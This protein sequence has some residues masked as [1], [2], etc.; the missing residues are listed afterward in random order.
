VLCTITEVAGHV[1]SLFGLNYPQQTEAALTRFLV[2][3]FFLL[4]NQQMITRITQD[5]KSDAQ[6]TN[7]D[8]KMFR[9]DVIV[10]RTLDAG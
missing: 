5:I 7:C 1:S 8:V 10:G 2:T 6:L 3:G 4:V 9:V